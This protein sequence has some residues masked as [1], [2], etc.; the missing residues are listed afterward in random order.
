MPAAAALLAWT[1]PLTM[2]WVRMRFS[3]SLIFRF[4]EACHGPL[5]KGFEGLGR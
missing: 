4:E 3:A 5:G 1:L 2:W